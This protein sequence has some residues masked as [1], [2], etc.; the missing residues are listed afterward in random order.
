M[1]EAELWAL[2]A[3]GAEQMG[4]A[5]EHREGAHSPASPLLPSRFT[6]CII[7]PVEPIKHVVF[8]VFI[9]LQITGLRPGMIDLSHTSD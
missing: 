7:I 3:V 6:G 1:A 4:R 8:V 9:V 2:V 5:G